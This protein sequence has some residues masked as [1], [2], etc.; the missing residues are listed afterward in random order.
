MKGISGRES[1]SLDDDKVSS[2]CVA[3][4][5]GMLSCPFFDCEC[6]ARAGSLLVAG[7]PVLGVVSGESAVVFMTFNGVVW[8]ASVVFLFFADECSPDS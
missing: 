7:L 5:I 8:A 3:L 1:E 6:L 2:L 4:P